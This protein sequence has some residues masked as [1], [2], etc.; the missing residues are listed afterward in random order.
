MGD[1]ISTF[2]G[3]NP[4]YYNTFYTAERKCEADILDPADT[5]WGMIIK[6]L[7][8]ELLVDNA[9]S[10]S[11]VSK[12]PQCEIESYGASDARTAF[13]GDNGLSPDVI[14]V[15]IGTNDWGWNVKVYPSEE[16]K[17]DISVFSV[18]YNEMLSKIKRNYPEAEVWRYTLCYSD[19]MLQKN[20]TL[21]FAEIT[22]TIDEYSRAIRACASEN[23]CRLLDLCRNKVGYTTIDDLHPD[24]NGM[25]MIAD[26]AL[27]ELTRSFGGITH[28]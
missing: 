21:P 22:G 9:W 15:Y 6:V 10:G 14:M 2:E 16:E 18:A 8:G 25:K 20:F 3:I 7:G 4:F 12:L 13:L 5:W 24:K 26:V 11:L 23:A 1:S 27:A 28:D 19:S 17:S